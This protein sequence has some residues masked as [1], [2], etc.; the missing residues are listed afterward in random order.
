MAEEKI[1]SDSLCEV[2]QRRLFIGSCMSLISTSVAFAVIGDIMGSLKTAFVL[3]NEQVGQVGGAALW[4]FT[5]SIIVLGPL[6]DFLKMKN[7]LRFSFGGM[8]AET[9]G[10]P[11]FIVLFLCMGI[12]ASLELGPNRWIPS[13]LQA[14]E[15]HGILVLVWI[16]GLMAVLRYFA[17]TTAV[18]E[19]V[20]RT[21]SAVAETAKEP[22]K[23]EILA[24]V[25]DAQT[26]LDESKGGKLPP[27]TANSL[28]HAIRAAASAPGSVEAAELAGKVK[29]LLDPADNFGGR[30][31]FRMLVPFSPIIILV[32]GTLY[33][34][35]RRKGGYK[36]EKIT[37]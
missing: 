8:V 32:F 2:H 16:S 1:T 34:Q 18:L 7:L 6:C 37:T 36:V 28:R 30:M 11:L 5:L 15:M 27:G 21:Y 9:L 24:A 31:S 22:F 17:G 35:D 14:G 4:G 13:I 12:T 29:A 33:L 3:T 26:T 23:Q 25:K 19:D 20:V 10:H